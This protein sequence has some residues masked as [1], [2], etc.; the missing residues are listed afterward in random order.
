MALTHRVSTTVRS[1][2]GSVTSTSYTLT[3]THEFNLELTDKSIA[4]DTLQDMVADVSTI[5]S[6]AIE[7]DVAM[8]LETNSNTGAGGD[9]LTLVANTPVIW[10]TTIAATTGAVCPLTTDVTALKPYDPLNRM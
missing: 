10:N 7:S 4:T 5:V 9:V 6:L 3:G 8:T 1:N 2:A